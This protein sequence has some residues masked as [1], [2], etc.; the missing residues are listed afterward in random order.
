[1]WQTQVMPRCGKGF[2]LNFKGLQ[3]CSRG[4]GSLP[5]KL[6]PCEVVL[7]DENLPAASEAQCPRCGGGQ[8][9]SFHRTQTTALE[10]SR[11]ISVCHSSKNKPPAVHAF[12]IGPFFNTYKHMSCAFYTQFL[13][14]AQHNLF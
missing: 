12:S 1:M 5:V 10:A 3:H 4:A 6:R 14:Q 13:L 11:F 9:N 7:S 2:E 8:T